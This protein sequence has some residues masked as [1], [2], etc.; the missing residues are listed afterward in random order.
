[1]PY[2]IFISSVV[3]L[4]RINSRF[5]F[6]SWFFS[7]THRHHFCRLSK[8]YTQKP[9]TQRQHIKNILHH[10]C[11]LNCIISFFAAKTDDIW[12][13]SVHVQCHSLEVQNL[14]SAMGWEAH[15]HFQGCES[16]RGKIDRNPGSIERERFFLQDFL[17]KNYLGIFLKSASTTGANHISSN[18]SQPSKKLGFEFCK[19]IFAIKW[20]ANFY[21]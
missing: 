11:R 20:L 16:V 18:F 9:H 5:S 12:F 7:S 1:M 8:S 10:S 15:F 6:T 21:F 2:F 3:F 17:I 14:H 19:L 13:S 4:Y